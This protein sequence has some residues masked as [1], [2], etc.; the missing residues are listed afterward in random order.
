MLLDKLESKISMFIWRGVEPW[1]QG[2]ARDSLASVATVWIRNTVECLSLN[3][4]LAW[5]FAFYLE[6]VRQSPFRYS[7]A[8]NRPS[9]ENVTNSPFFSSF[10]S[11][12]NQFRVSV[13]VAKKWNSTQPKY[14]TTLPSYLRKCTYVFIRMIERL[15]IV[16]P[17]VYVIFICARRNIRPFLCASPM[18]FSRSTF[19]SRMHFSGEKM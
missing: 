9:R 4:D 19:I 5:H 10:F 8:R 11:C 6:Y 16:H 15:Y 17:L 13:P 2:P 12:E 18:T 3:R 7:P 1:W 14:T